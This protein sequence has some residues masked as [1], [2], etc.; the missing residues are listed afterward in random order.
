[1]GP[2]GSVLYSGREPAVA[3]N[4]LNH[5]YFVVWRGDDDAPP[6]VAGE[7]EVFGQRLDAA[8]GAPIGGRIRLSDMGPD[9]NPAYDAVAPAVAYNSTNNQY[10]VVWQGDDDTP[11][12]VDGELEI[13]GQLID[14]A[15]G[16]E[17]GG[18]FRISDMG[19]DGDEDHDAFA[20]AV[21]YNSARNEYL[22]VWYGDDNAFPNVNG[23]L[24]IF[25]QRIDAATGAEIGGDFRISD[26][27]PDSDPQYDALEPAVVYNP[28]ADHYLVVW[29]A[30]DDAGGL[31]VDEFE[32]YGQF[33]D[34]AGAE[35]GPNDFR[36]SDMGSDGNPAFDAERPSVAPN[37]AGSEYL[38]V[39][40][41]DDG[42]APLVDDEREIHGQ[43]I[44]AVTF[45]EIG[46]ND[47][48]ISDMGPDGSAAF[49]ADL[50]SVAF[51][52]ARNRWIVVWTGDDDDDGLVDD[53]REL[54]LQEIDAAAGAETGLNDSRV[55]R[56]G[57]D[58]DPAFQAFGPSPIVFNP[59]TAES[60][61]VWRAD[62]GAAPLVDNE[63]EI[64]GLRMTREIDVAPLAVG[65]GEWDID[66]G[67][68]TGV[69]VTISNLGSAPLNL[70]SVSLTGL[71][72]SHYVILDDTG[73]TSIAPGSSRIVTVAF[74][75][76][77]VGFKSAAITIVS[78]DSDEPTIVVTLGG[79]GIDQELT[80]TGGPVAFGPFDVDDGPSAAMI[81]NVAN[82][83]TA[84]L[85]FT[86]F[87]FRL[88]GAS[89]QNF[90]FA[91]PPDASPLIP[92]AFFQVGVVFN[93]I[94]TGNKNA[95]LEIESD[96]G[97]ASIA[98]NGSGIDQEIDVSPLSLDFGDRIY[99]TGPSSPLEVAIANIGTAPLNLTGAGAS[100]GGPNA[101]EFELQAPP[102][103]GPIAPGAD[104]RISIVFNPA[105]FGVKSASL[106]VA[107]DDSDEPVVE[108]PLAG[109]AKAPSELSAAGPSWTIYR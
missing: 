3:Y 57:V 74:D 44:S 20:P 18:D 68:T 104:A 43:R 89:P 40:S 66:D 63:F 16:A 35:I 97:N 90:A 24:E 92:G 53:E 102:N 79:T 107:S 72:A 19:P 1:M 76:F 101:A 105:S 29:R 58:G 27:G 38:V 67:P 73:Q 25:A 71:S 12:L 96:G 33:L 82:T 8:T 47:F 9:G 61:A 70:A 36:I 48:R 31:V 7:F 17:I 64:Y 83:G 50:P 99:G 54:F 2:D 95:A 37:A 26:A 32:I 77:N 15:T 100:I 5:E 65:F 4:S 88:A 93:P 94:S 80:V 60:F 23:E 6:L 42:A 34:S 62:E 11:P 103:P 109:I 75:P 52:S 55:S 39:W 98:L 14:A 87:Q 22:V 91:A 28:A 69:L 46:A 51:D 59:V 78:D 106:I 30:S 85:H 13:F 41:G 45:A 108:I 10:L 84:T 56:I 49:V 21:A 81:L 86:G